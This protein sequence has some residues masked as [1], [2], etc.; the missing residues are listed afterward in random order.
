MPYVHKKIGDSNIRAKWEY[1]GFMA[2]FKMLYHAV[3]FFEKTV[4][5]S[6]NKTK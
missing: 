4:L 6:Y 5:N 1:W 3:L 2:N